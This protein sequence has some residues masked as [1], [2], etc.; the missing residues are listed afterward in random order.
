KFK[1]YTIVDA[2]EKVFFKE[3]IE[4]ASMDQVAQEAELSKGTL[5]LYF[6]SK[7]E[8]YR[9]I[10]LRGFIILKR[11]LKEAALPQENGFQNVKAISEAYIKFS[12]DYLGYFNAILYYQND[13]FS[14]KN[15]EPSEVQSL[16]GGNAVIAILIN[17]IQKGKID[18]SVNPGANE[19]EIAFVLW[20]QITGLL[21]VIQRKMSIITYHYK[22]KRDD[23]LQTYYELLERSL[24]A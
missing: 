12:Y 17:A 2:A 4:R 16:E 11:K 24:K 8:L 19:V 1:A 3:G 23:L 18:R 21:Q 20:S 14:A 5:Y 9:A 13:I 10:I 7:D 15:R 6:K 22:I